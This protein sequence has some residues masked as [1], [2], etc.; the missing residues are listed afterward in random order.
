MI[1]RAILFGGKAIV[2]VMDTTSTVQKTRV[3]L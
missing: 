1:K 2:S 3:S